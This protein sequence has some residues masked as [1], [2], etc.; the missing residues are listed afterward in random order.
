MGDAL[1]FVDPARPECGLL[2]DGRLAEDFKLS[3]G[4]WVSVGPLRTRILQQAGAYVQDVVIAA[5]DRAFVG[6]LV[7][8]NVWA[9]RTLCPD[10][11]ADA[12]P[13]VVL[14]DARVREMFR[15]L[16]QRLAVTSTGSSTFVA[17]ALLLCDP[18]S[19]DAREITDKGSI[20]QKAV[21]AN[22]ASLVEA[23]YADSPSEDVILSRT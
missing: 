10:L 16:F 14:G 11:A 17:R 7:F 15:G 1:R 12:S 4:T 8:P 6:A 18:P 9:C 2:F 21:L 5:P 19:I 13:D 22:R 23:L 3:N 20:N